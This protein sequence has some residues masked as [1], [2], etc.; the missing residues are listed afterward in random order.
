MTS[1]YCRAKV[2]EEVPTIDVMMQTAPMAK[3]AGSSSSLMKLRSE[4]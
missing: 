1:V 4:K 3:A 2:Y